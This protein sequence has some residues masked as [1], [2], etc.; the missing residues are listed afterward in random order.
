MS[1]F[2]NSAQT[3]LSYV[4]EVTFGTTPGGP[5]MLKFR[6]T[7]AD[8][9]LDKTI[10]KSDE[11]RTDGQVPFLR[12]GNRRVKGTVKGQLSYLAYKDLIRAWLRY[13]TSGSGHGVSTA[14]VN[15]SFVSG[16][17]TIHRT[18]GS[19]VTD[20]F[21]ANQKI[22]VTGAA[23]AGNNTVLTIASLTASDIT[24]VE[25]V[26][27][28]SATNNTKIN[29]DY[30]ENQTTDKSFSVEAGFTDIVQYQVLKGLKVDKMNVS[31]KPNS[32]VDLTFDLVGQDSAAFSGSSL[33]A[34]TDVDTSDPCDTTTG[35]VQE[36]GAASAIISGADFSGAWNR[37]LTEVLGAAIPQ[38]IEA[39]MFDVS[40]TITAFFADAT[41][42]NKFISE[43]LTSLLIAFT[44][45][46]NNAIYFYFPAVK[47]TG[48]SK[49]ISGSSDVPLKL[50][51]TAY[52]DATTGKTCI[53]N[54]VPG[55]AV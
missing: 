2:A 55:V 37:Q 13:P 19:W 30:A 52:R 38:T 3:Q 4:P 24:V 16:S 26:T 17:K 28:E 11:R 45:P 46:A 14:G 20:G 50:P 10:L 9:D 29:G 47:Y 54:M 22:R 43:T 25:A 7:S 27:T 6:F 42:F 34:P 32:M 51:F 48:G 49:S 1:V 23:Q 33:G 44:D 5:S 8:L 15:T 36:G 12:H 31:A 53:V 21:V 18:S 39:G 35:S 40:G 41:L